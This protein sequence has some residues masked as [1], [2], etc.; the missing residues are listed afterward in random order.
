MFPS[1]VFRSWLLLGIATLTS[2]LPLIKAQSLSQTASSSSIPGL[3]SQRFE[4]TDGILANTQ[5]FAVQPN[6]RL[7]QEELNKLDVSAV[8]WAA[9]DSSGNPRPDDIGE[10]W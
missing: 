6:T 4:V 10:S 8:D 5:V 7:L 9:T 3:A 2:F 1:V